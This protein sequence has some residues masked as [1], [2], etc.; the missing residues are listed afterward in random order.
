MGWPAHKVYRCFSAAWV[1]AASESHRPQRAL[2]TR[3]AQAD[4]AAVAPVERA[5]AF[6]QAADLQ[7]LA[8]AQPCFGRGIVLGARQAFEKAR[9]GR[10]LQ[11]SFSRAQAFPT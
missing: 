6:A 2:G 8:V 3:F 5:D 9:Q 7:Y 10:E 4:H 11:H 1:S